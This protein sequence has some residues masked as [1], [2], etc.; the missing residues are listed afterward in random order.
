MKFQLKNIIITTK[1][2]TST[3]RKWRSQGLRYGVANG[4][5]HKATTSL[6]PH[7]PHACM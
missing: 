6:P 5:A 4:V 2:V 3:G 1:L 7:P